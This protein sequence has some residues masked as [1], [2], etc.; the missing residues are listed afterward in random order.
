LKG[1][2]RLAVMKR[3]MISKEQALRAIQNVEF[4]A[5]VTASNN[6]VAIVMTQD[7]CGEWM[8]MKRW[9]DSMEDIKGLDI[10]ELIYNTVDYYNDFL[11]LKEKSWKNDLIPYIRYYT[12]GVLVRQSNYVKKE[13]F[14]KIVELQNK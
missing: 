6:R 1:S 9:M 5:D 13:D 2:R 11:K 3:K 4:G 7:W 10:Y 14:L 12:D 8:A